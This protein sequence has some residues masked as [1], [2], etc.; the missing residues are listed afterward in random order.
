MLSHHICRIFGGTLLSALGFCGDWFCGSGKVL[1]G[2]GCEAFVQLRGHDAGGEFGELADVRCQGGIS[3]A[4]MPL[5]TNGSQKW[6]WKTWRNRSAM[7]LAERMR[8]SCSSRMSETGIPIRATAAPRSM[9]ASLEI[10]NSVPSSST[11][12]I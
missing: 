1:L 2:D 12:P 7:P 6:R 10:T 5:S 11:R 9:K 3:S 8:A 4:G